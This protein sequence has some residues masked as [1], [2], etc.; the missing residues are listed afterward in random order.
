MLAFCLIYPLKTKRRRTISRYLF[1]YDY[2]N[3]SRREADPS[4]LNVK[5]KYN[6]PLRSSKIITSI[7]VMN[8]RS[9]R[10]KSKR[11][12]ATNSQ[13]G[14]AVLPQRSRSKQSLS[15]SSKTSYSLER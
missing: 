13:F 11:T 1:I 12:N 6:Y 5:Y 2:Y 14:A 10:A 9:A 7:I 15:P 4:R 3:K 8:V